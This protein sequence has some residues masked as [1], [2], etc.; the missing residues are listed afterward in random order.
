MNNDKTIAAIREQAKVAEKQLWKDG[1]AY[2]LHPTADLVAFAADYE[3][4]RTRL[5]EYEEMFDS[6]GVADIG[7]RRFVKNNV[8][9][10]NNKWSEQW[11][12]GDLN[13][14][15]NIVDAFN[16]LRSKEREG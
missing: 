2:S 16:A 1:V 5:A 4:M 15:E 8:R 12:D 13:E 7:T 9:G 10:G 6:V 11:V 3:E 14:H